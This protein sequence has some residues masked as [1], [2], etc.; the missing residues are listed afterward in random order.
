MIRIII[1]AGL[2][3]LVSG[4]LA[5]GSAPA[6]G[7]ASPPHVNAPAGAPPA[8]ASE[9]PIRVSML[10]STNWLA[11]HLNDPRVR[12]LEVTRHPARYAEGHIPGAQ[13]LK[14]DDVA[15][16]RGGLPNEIPPLETLVGLVQRLGIEPGDRIILYDDQEGIPASRAWMVFDYLG[17]GGQASVL[18]GQLAKWRTE[19]RALTTV[20]PNVKSSRFVPTVNPNVV[21][22]LPEVRDMAG[23]ARHNPDARVA[24]VDARPLTEYQGE[25]AG[26]GISRG[27]HIPGAVNV[28]SKA[29][30][31]PGEAPILKSPGEL[32]KLYAAAGVRPGDKV[33]TY[34]RTGGQASQDYFVLKYLGYD[35]RIYDGSFYEW[36]AQPDT[37]VHT[38]TAK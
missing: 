30:L 19:G 15:T 20:V 31:A 10:V 9:Q 24:I 14:W 4:V 7:Q 21:V 1:L 12:I 11:A 32:G 16:T 18:N 35:P 25:K 13:L 23:E 22:Y 27:G 17:L 3:L 36:S 29:N 26:A 8:P 38:G 33:I 5:A 34:C 2:A 37:K 6:G 28:P